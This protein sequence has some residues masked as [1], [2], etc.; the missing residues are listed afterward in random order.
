MSVIKTNEALRGVIGDKVDALEA[1][2]TD[3]IDEF[4]REFIERSP[5]LILS[6]ADADGNCDA[7]PK[8]DAPGFV[9]ILDKKTIL[10]PDRPGNKLAYGH[11]NVLSNPHVGLLFMIPGTTE[12][13][14]V[15]GRAELDA[16]DELRDQLAARNKPAT[17]VLRVGVGSSRPRDAG[18]ASSPTPTQKSA[19]PRSA[20]PL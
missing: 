20:M 12:T 3:H 1:K 9:K 4:A 6:T 18:K 15:N 17:L 11:E 2:V 16:S 14:R 13:L 7:S 10:I 19:H 8:G 5:F